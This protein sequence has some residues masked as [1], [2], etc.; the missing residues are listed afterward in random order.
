MVSV[1]VVYCL[2]EAGVYLLY[3][4]IN[5]CRI[6]EY[7]EL[8]VAGVVPQVLLLLLGLREKQQQ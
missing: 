5:S 6:R 8:G 2:M 1:S 3:N 7:L 4:S